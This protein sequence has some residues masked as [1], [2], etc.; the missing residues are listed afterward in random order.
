MEKERKKILLVHTGLSTFVK[1]DLD[2]LRKE[3]E[4]TTYYYDT[5]GLQVFVVLRQF[6]WLLF[7]VW[8]FNKVY[9]WFGDYHAFFPILFSRLLGKTSFLVVGGYD[10]C[11]IR[12]LRYGVFCNP[13]R[14]KVV[15][16]VMRYCTLNLCVSRYVE[17]KVRA[18]AGDAKT[19]LLYN[20]TNIRQTDVSGDYKRNMILTVASIDTGRTFYRKGMP[21]VLDLA[22]ELP[23]YEF[24]IVG[25]DSQLRGL[26]DDVSPNVTIYGKLPQD[27]LVDYYRQAKVYCQ[28]SRMDTF[29]LALAEGMLYNC[30][31]V[32]TAVGGMPEVVG[33]TGYVVAES[34]LD[35]LPGLVRE[36]MTRPYSNRY[37]ERIERN[38]L[39]ETRER[40]LL[41]ILGRY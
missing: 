41:E 6:F 12:D 17:R 1:G 35:T 15:R 32:V 33:D 4:V 11:R 31:P 38:F 7:N 19:T 39:L 20:G 29:C 8:R 21:R 25:L 10:V 26:C 34:H 28:L 40:K 13:L 27:E 37:R 18:V 22:K 36:A 30:V 23:E 14:G 9:I 3:Y 24:V 5:R 16:F 2:V